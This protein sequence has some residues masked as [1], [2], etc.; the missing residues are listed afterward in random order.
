[1][2]AMSPGFE[3][4][5]TTRK[6][7][8]RG[9]GL[10]KGL[11]RMLAGESLFLNHFTATDAEQTLIVGPRLLGDVVHRRLQ[12]GSMIVQGSSWLASSTDI[13]IDATCQ[14]FGKALFSGEGMFWLKCSGEGDLFLSSFGAI[15][16][17]EVDG[18]YVVDTGHIVAFDETLQFAIRKAGASWIGSFLGGEGLVCRFSGQGRLLCQSHNPPGFGALLG[19]KLKPR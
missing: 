3:V 13:A 17:V 19:P 14:G 16:E 15:Y 11:K 7:N 1:M 10:L 8:S 2:I 6:K 18:D 12:S 9:G 5:T 4:E